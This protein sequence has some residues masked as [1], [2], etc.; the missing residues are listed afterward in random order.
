MLLI[1]GSACTFNHAV[2]DNTACS[3]G[4]LDFENIRNMTVPA[5]FQ[6]WSRPT[7]GCACFRMLNSGMGSDLHT[8]GQAL[9]NM[10]QNN[11]PCYLVEKGWIWD[12]HGNLFDLPWVANCTSVSFDHRGKSSI[13]HISRVAARATAL[14]FVLTLVRP[15]VYAAACAA[16][17]KLQLLSGKRP[18]VSVHIRWGDKQ[19]EMKLVA[20]ETYVR[21]VTAFHL[22]D[23]L[24]FVTSEDKNAVDA[25]RSK[26]P[27][28]WQV[29][30]YSAATSP[31]SSGPNNS[32]VN[33]A[34]H[35]PDAGLHS[36]V[37]LMLAYQGS[38]FV[39]TTGSNWSR[40]F[41]ELCYIDTLKS[42]KITDLSPQLGW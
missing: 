14:A 25:F 4:T 7:H 31:L 18:I 27:N 24:I 28:H 17:G 20:I 10:K 15:S 3:S 35:Q 38:H 6:H 37:S 34:S 5:P 39:L 19:R 11:E 29:T 12:L 23:P 26:A 41:N 9:W 30:T 16:A 36:L 32:P 22:V 2:A 1:M 40:L 33:F 8:F 13:S 21:A 42:C